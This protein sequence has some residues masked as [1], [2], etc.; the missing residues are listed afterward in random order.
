MLGRPKQKQKAFVV[1]LTSDD[2][3]G[4]LTKLCETQLTS[5]AH[6]SRHLQQNKRR[7][8]I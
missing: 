7:A 5:L 4:I 3:D 8:V 6:S 2:R 1:G